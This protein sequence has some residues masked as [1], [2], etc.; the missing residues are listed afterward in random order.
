MNCPHGNAQPV[1]VRVRHPDVGQTSFHV[2][3]CT[4]GM[5]F[6]TTKQRRKNRKTWNNKRNRH[7][8][9]TRGMG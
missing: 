7:E 3:S 2:M 8:R 1:Q 4:C 6:A 9:M 5:V